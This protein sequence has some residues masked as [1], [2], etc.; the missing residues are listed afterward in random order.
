MRAMQKPPTAT[1]AGTLR[2]FAGFLAIVA[3]LAGLEIYTLVAHNRERATAV[4]AVVAPAANEGKGPEGAIDAPAAEAIVGPRVV[5]SGWALDAA[6]IRAVEIRVDGKAFPARIGIERLDVGR[7]KARMADS[8]HGGFEWS[9]DLSTLPAAPGTDRRTIAI[10]VVAKD[11]R[12]TVL[13]TRS[14]IDAAALARW[15]G[16][17]GK[18]TAPFYLLPA[19]SGLDLGG[20]AELDKI[21]APYLSPTLRAGFRVPVLYLR[22]TKGMAGDYAFDPEWDPTRKCGERRIADDSLGSVL[23]HAREKALP[24]LV[25]LNGGIWADAFCDVPQWDVNDRLEQDV[26]NC[27]WNENNEVMP[28][29][30]LKTLPGSLEA[31]ELARSL[32]LNVYASEVRRY[33]KRNLQQAGAM[34]AA[35]ARENPDLFVGVNLDPDTYMNPFFAEKQWYDYNPGTLRQFREWL[36]G[37]G[38][39]AGR[40]GSGVPD[41]RAYRRVKPL[42][43]AEVNALA[44]THWKSWQEVDAPRTFVRDG[45]RPFWKDPWVH[46]WEYFRRHLVHLHYDELAKWLVEA[47]ISRDHIWSSQ[48]LMAPRGDSMP[49]AIDLDSPTRNYDSGGMSIRGAKPELGHLGVILYGE[50]AV[51][52][53]AMDNGRSLFATLASVDPSWAVVEYNTADLRDIKVAPTY[54]AAYRGLRDLWNYGAR[55]VSPMAWNGSNGLFVGQPGYATFTAWRNTPLEAAARDFMLARAG[56][57]LGSLLWTFGTPAFADGDGWTADIGTVALGK[58]FLVL[59]PDANDRMAIVSPKGLPASV[60]RAETFVLGLDEHAG[61]RRVRIQGRTG[62]DGGWETL[63]DA[64]AGA[65]QATRAGIAVKRRAGD[66]GFAFD[67]LR[68][69]I[70]FAANTSRKLARVAAL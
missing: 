27:Q 56:L 42:T 25:T 16:L 23:R 37:T 26:R 6:G 12:E 8:A 33:K 61:V 60:Q 45:S 58:G 70:T 28:D 43:L 14:V 29:D 44:G 68:I 20:A 30:M 65:L 15:T 64:S 47:G 35:F 54:A 55:F 17:A 69:E 10:V 5:V 52:D 46:E 57:P 48:G 32:T 11:G 22:T 7:L 63:A 4:Q 62:P 49:F 13:G 39:Y 2:W 41:L 36:S 34:L 9:G 53:V 51:N 19:L 1:R 31:P 66:R 40:G 24:V 59:G 67:Q 3:A 38:P 50:A 18:S 21:Y